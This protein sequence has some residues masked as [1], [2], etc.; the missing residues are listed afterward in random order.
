MFHDLKPGMAF[1]CAFLCAGAPPAFCQQEGG[2]EFFQSSLGEILDT[3][4]LA[5][6]YSEERPSDAAATAY[7]ITAET[8]EKRGYST[9]TDLL[10]DIPQ[11]QV[12]RN[13]DTGRL[14]I[15]SVRGVPYNE[16]VVILYDGI[17]VTP[18]TGDLVGL[19]GQFSL[20]TAERVEIVIG[21]MSALYGAD[22]FSGVVNIVTRKPFQ[23]A[24]GARYGSFKS[25]AGSVSASGGLPP[26][27]PA[28]NSGEALASVAYETQSS[29]G[30]DLPSL[31]KNDFS[32]FNHEYRSGQVKLPDSSIKTVPVE[33]YDS[34]ASS[35]FLNARLNLGGFETGLIKMRES[36]SSST[37]VKPDMSVYGE[38]SRFITEN[39]TLYGRHTYAA[40]DESW[41]L[42]SL[43][44]HYSYTIDPATKFVNSFSGYA[45]AYKYASAQTNS[46]E[47]ILSLEPAAGFPALIGV[48]YQENTVLPYTSDLSHKFD[49]SLSPGSQGFTY[50]GSTIPVDFYS[51]RYANTGAFMQVQARE[52]GN[53]AVS[54][55]L[56]YDYSTAYGATWNPRAGIVWKPGGE[57]RTVV[58]LLYGEAYLAPSPFHTHRHF[59]SFVSSPTPTGYYSY[60][61]HVPSDDLD[62]EKIRSVE[63]DL[64][65][66]FGHGLRVSLNPYYNKVRNLIQDVLT[67]PGT[68]HGVEVLE[69]E[70]AM[71]LGTMETYG[72]T[73]RA[74]AVLRS[75]KWSYEPWA[76]YTYSDG[77]LAGSALPFNSRHVIQ[78]GCSALRGRWVF[79]P[80][81][82]YRS[83]SRDYD[84]IRVPQFTVVDLSV[85]YSF[86][87][88]K[89]G[90]VT[91]YLN[92]KNIF[93]RRYYNGSYGGGQDHLEGAPQAPFS[94]EAGFNL[95]F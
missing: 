12:Q 77:R 72:S 67:G 24:A 6:S 53:A 85:R 78:T 66:S 47:E 11:L 87:R 13:S 58:K 69:I 81:A 8:I 32:W 27:R 71:N 49:T 14:N 56:R 54:L 40:S 44:S 20:K 28:D 61:F 57:E 89:I 70:K 15:L 5:A 64:T 22:A 75:G 55:G 46:L 48:S 93:D 62:P 18:P 52:L 31:Y 95:K 59:G 45:D 21:P 33:K 68:F 23:T 41:K 3:P 26:E 39:W 82:L 9:L 50:A 92:L 73:L 36:H 37:G 19:G 1:L 25:G 16:R 10:N 4:M 80:K 30:P 86:S 90:A 43:I 76:A 42:S 17:R 7:V 88:M 60:F 65:H 84:G 79:T 38:D 83:F 51:L 35:S 34:S 74:D 2:V 91:A 29:A 94:A 63:A